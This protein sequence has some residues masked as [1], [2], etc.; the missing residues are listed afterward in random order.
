MLQHHPGRRGPL[1]YSIVLVVALSGCGGDGGGAPPPENEPPG[2]TLAVA[3]PAADEFVEFAR[4]TVQASAISDP[5]GD[6]LETEWL[7]PGDVALLD[8]TETSDN[9]IEVLSFTVPRVSGH[10][11]TSLSFRV[12]D[13]THEVIDELPLKFREGNALFFF[14]DDDDEDTLTELYRWHE[15]MT[16]PVRVGPVDLDDGTFNPVRPGF[17]QAYALTRQKDK[18]FLVDSQGTVTTLLE[19]DAGETLNI[20]RVAW[21]PDGERLAA[22]VQH[23]GGGT[24]SHQLTVFEFE[25]ELLDG[26]KHF[27]PPNAGQLVTQGF[28]WSSSGKALTLTG[29]WRSGGLFESAVVDVATN[30][31]LPVLEMAPDEV[32]VEACSWSPKG[33]MVACNA[34]ING[35]PS[36]IAVAT[37]ATQERFIVADS[38]FRD[39][40]LFS[41]ARW[42]ANGQW[43]AFRGSLREAGTDEVYVYDVETRALLYPTAVPDAGKDA[44]QT[45]FWSPE[46]NLLAFNERTGTGIFHIHLLAC[47][48]SGACTASDVTGDVPPGT[49]ASPTFRGWSADG[50]YLAFDGRLGVLAGSGL[51]VFGVRV[52]ANGI[53]EPRRVLSGGRVVANGPAPSWSPAG[54]RLWLSTENEMREDWQFGHVNAGS[55][56]VQPPLA[57]LQG[58][59]KAM[60][61]VHWTA[62]GGAIL[63]VQRRG[64]TDDTLDLFFSVLAE[65][66][67]FDGMQSLFD[68]PNGMNGAE[69]IGHAWLAGYWASKQ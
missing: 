19:P 20:P 57:T 31:I 67:A 39:G 28:S 4:I 30:S 55:S 3:E 51:E 44:G 63:H 66:D 69:S 62:D 40:T 10:A 61:E 26:E 54:A 11:E 7:L 59:D 6:D 16:M 43:L 5:D 42:A 45:V 12:F 35:A 9:G 37:H 47:S 27:E 38:Q 22:V 46:R 21:S 41:F 8:V 53:A 64:A 33:T 24:E 1:K 18:L 68:W 32:Q 58:A 25:G 48:E 17:Q 23:V 50:E 29:E 49:K 65:D 36:Q 15:S 14:A 56:D 13:G 2:F 52:D 34:K 60:H